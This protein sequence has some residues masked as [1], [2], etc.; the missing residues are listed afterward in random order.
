MHNL[1]LKSLHEVDD[2][3]SMY[4]MDVLTIPVNLAGLPGLSV[5]M[6][7]TSKGLPTGLQLIG[8]PFDEATLLNVAYAWEQHGSFTSLR[9]KLET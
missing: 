1:D 4:L 6:S 9:P 7:L 3:L 8:R 5:T 2:P